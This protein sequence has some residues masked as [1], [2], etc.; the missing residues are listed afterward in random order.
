MDFLYSIS[1]KAAPLL[2]MGIAVSLSWA[3]CLKNKLLAKTRQLEKTSKRL[4]R[5][6]EHAF[7]DAVTETYN[8]KYFS[9]RLKDSLNQAQRNH[10][11]VSLIK[12]DIELFKNVNKIYGP[13]NGDVI[14]KE[15]SDFLKNNLR[16]YDVVAR[17]EGDEFGIICSYTDKKR[18]LQLSRR[19]KKGLNFNSF[20]KDG[21]GLQVSIGLVTYPDDGTSLDTLLSLL[22]R[23]LECSKEKHNKIVALGELKSNE[24]ADEELLLSDL[25]SQ[26]LRDKISELKTKLDK[27]VLEAIIAFA[28]T[29]KAKDLYTAEHTEKTVQLAVDIA[30]ELQFDSTQ[31]ETVK[32]A[33]MIH[34]LGKI[35]VSESILRKPGK[36]TDEEFKEIK[37]HPVIGSEILRPLHSLSWVI[38]S[39]LYHHERID[40]K[41]YPFELKGEQIPIEAKIVAL[42]D[43]FQA[44]TSDRPY[45][46]AYSLK[47]AEE[48]IEEETGTHFDPKVTEA[49][50]RSL[51]NQKL[52]S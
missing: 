51:L 6:K 5:L 34:D 24:N 22:D 49:F 18:A 19:I 44:L 46:K 35:G 32:Y 28:N 9:H 45:R 17:L 33:A 36:L 47:K 48:I 23:C 43:S 1:L 42:A 30:K 12:I 4:R 10:Y 13:L 50:R 26:E 52:K 3:L 21:I 15:F 38:P 29:I 7:I 2:V 40:G 37:R 41:G 14:L 16:T 31:I 25:K 11:P 39:I 27:T 20:G 8:Y